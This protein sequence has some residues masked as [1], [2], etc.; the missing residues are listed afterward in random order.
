MASSNIIELQ[1]CSELLLEEAQ[2]SLG[3]GLLGGGS[4]ASV[5]EPRLNLLAKSLARLYRGSNRQ[6]CLA[7]AAD[8]KLY[9]CEEDTPSVSANGKINPKGGKKKRVLNYWCFCPGI[10]ML[11]LKR[12]GV[13][14]ILL[15]SGT[16]SPMSSFR[17]D[18]RLHF[19]I[20]LENPHVIE[21][22]QIW[23]GSLSVRK[24]VL[25]Y[26]ILDYIITFI[27]LYCFINPF[28]PSINPFPPPPPFVSVSRSVPVANN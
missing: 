9:V 22:S 26:I 1:R 12:L 20:E 15:T 16:L 24:N 10:A 11:E 14:S 25:E 2:S 3:G 19:N 21:R 8:Y 7:G 5:P 18:M 13:R 23:V 28:L 17:D 27:I 6:E 4:P